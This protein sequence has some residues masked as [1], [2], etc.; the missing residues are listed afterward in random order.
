MP[1][2]VY[3]SLCAIP[4]VTCMLLYPLV[5]KPFAAEMADEGKFVIIDGLR[6]AGYIASFNELVPRI[7]TQLWSFGVTVFYDYRLSVLA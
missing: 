2:F 4:F 5:R 3:L 1:D 7:L 6:N